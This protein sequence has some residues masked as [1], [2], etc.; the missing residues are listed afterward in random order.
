MKLEDSK[1][2]KSLIQKQI[3]WKKRYPF[4][5]HTPWSFIF[6]GKFN[7][8]IAWLNPENQKHIKYGWITLQ[9]IK[10]WV[11]EKPGKIIP[12]KGTFENL[13][14]ELSIPLNLWAFNPINAS[15]YRQHFKGVSLNYSEETGYGWKKIVPYGYKKKNSSNYHPLSDQAIKV[16]ESHIKHLIVDDLFCQLNIY[17]Y[18]DVEEEIRKKV[19]EEFI[20]SFPSETFRYRKFIKDEICGFFNALYYLGYGDYDA[21]NIPKGDGIQNLSF[22][23]NRLKYE[24]EYDFLNLCGML[25]EDWKIN[26]NST[27]NR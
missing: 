24:A 9:D 10:D 11:D 3:E 26:Y 19:F 18:K 14:F 4:V 5:W 23:E 8:E 17:S 22:W 20:C 1:E 25:P 2:Y 27:I 16:I 15:V 13:K 6:L 21:C 7:G 12:D